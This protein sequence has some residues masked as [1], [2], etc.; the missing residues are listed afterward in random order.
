MIASMAIV[1][2]TFG[3][4]RSGSLSRSA[5]YV[6]TF[7][8]TRRFNV[9]WTINSSSTIHSGLWLYSAYRSCV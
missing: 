4:V 9:G 7:L 6:S 1:G 3:G 5:T 2:A 8:E